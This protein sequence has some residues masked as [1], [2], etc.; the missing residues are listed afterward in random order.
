MSA[1]TFWDNYRFLIQTGEQ[2][3][4]QET[5]VINWFEALVMHLK[6]MP[7]HGRVIYDLHYTACSVLKW[8]YSNL[9]LS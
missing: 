7:L 1:C 3:F 4:M 9:Y 8:S 2:L 5:I 6:V